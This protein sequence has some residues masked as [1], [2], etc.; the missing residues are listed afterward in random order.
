MPERIVIARRPISDEADA[1]AESFQS[2]EPFGSFA[3]PEPP[4]RREWPEWRQWREWRRSPVIVAG[5]VLVVALLGTMSFVLLRGSGHSG[6]KEAVRAGESASATANAA[7]TTTAASA[8]PADAAATT[9]SPTTAATAVPATAAPAETGPP[10]TLPDGS[11]PP[12]IAIFGGTHVT[13]SGWVSS[14]A[15]FDRLA[16][17]A[18]TNSKTGAPV[19]NDTKIDPRVPANVGV[20]VVELTSARFPAGRVDVLPD[21]ATEL[22]RVVSIMNAM[23]NVTALV[24]GHADQRGTSDVNL[25]LSRWRAQAV[26]D[27]LVSQGVNAERLSSK[28]VG[29]D[30]PLT[31]DTSDAAYA[32]NRR[33]E[34]VFYGLLAGA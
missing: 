10:P 6:S 30:E 4:G 8:A 1:P 28:A 29:A 13:L 14:Q 24:I 25:K 15:A 21:H 11:W 16:T 12:I 23:P 9:A 32:L 22:N 34:F 3:S 26:V 7:A 17:L 31:Q 2:F 27:Y 5:G 20:R 33:T 19:E 18:A